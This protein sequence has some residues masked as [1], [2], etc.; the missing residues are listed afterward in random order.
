[1]VTQRFF[2]FTP[3]PGENDPI[4]LTI[5]QMGW[6]N[7]QLVVV[8]FFLGGGGWGSIKKNFKRW[9]T[10]SSNG[11]VI[12]CCLGGGRG[13]GKV[14]K[15]NLLIERWHGHPCARIAQNDVN[16]QNWTTS[17]SFFPSSCNRK[18]NHEKSPSSLGGLKDVLA[19]WKLP[20]PLGNDPVW[21]VVVLFGFGWSNYQLAMRSVEILCHII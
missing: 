16:R 7:H 11:D 18:K 1:M 3:N 4:W 9:G 21:K 12:F 15:R 14:W 13:R 19:M 2:M 5:F 8:C 20:A 6:F 10:N 17:W